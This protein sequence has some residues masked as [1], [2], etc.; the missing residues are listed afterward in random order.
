MVDG[1]A[2]PSTSGM[3]YEGSGTTVVAG[4]DF[5]LP[6]NCTMT[7]LHSAS[8]H[9]MGTQHKMYMYWQCVIYQSVGGDP[10]P[11]RSLH[12]APQAEGLTL[13]APERP[14]LDCDNICGTS[15]V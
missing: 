5:F 3:L 4:L 2:P 12:T 15:V 13:A 8:R 14:L 6:P 9:Y 7:V 10:G 1:F 11:Q